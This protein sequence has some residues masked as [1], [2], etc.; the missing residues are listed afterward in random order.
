[1]GREVL[2]YLAADIGTHS[3][4]LGCAMALH[5]A[6]LPEYAIKLIGC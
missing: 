2:G 3:L 1:M 5:L 4:R 6:E